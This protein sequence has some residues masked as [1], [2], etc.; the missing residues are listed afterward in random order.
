MSALIQITPRSW[1]VAKTV[2]EPMAAYL[3]THIRITLPQWIDLPCLPYVMVWAILLAAI[4][5]TTNMCICGISIVCQLAVLNCYHVYPL[6]EIPGWLRKMQACMT[7][8]VVCALETHN[9]DV[10]QC[11]DKYG[12]VDNHSY[13][14]DEG[15]MRPVGGEGAKTRSPDM[16]SNRMPSNEITIKE[17]EMNDENLR[18]EWKTLGGHCDCFL[19]VS[20]AVIHVC[21]ILIV[22]V[23]LPFITKA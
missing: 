17:M 14:H 1:S 3:L 23:I 11:A 20:F 19:F 18:L 6:R 2:S 22:V 12:H 7:C 4:Y 10:H 13:T 8:A 21:V 9:D 5:L 15:N 16:R